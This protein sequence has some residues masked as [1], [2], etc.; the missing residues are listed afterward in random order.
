MQARSIKRTL[1]VALPLGILIGASGA[2][3]ANRFLDEADGHVDRA[4]DALQKA[5][6]PSEQGEYGG[7]RKRAIELLGD[8]KRQIKK[9]REYDERHPT[10][11]APEPKPDAGP[12]P[13]PTGNPGPQPK[14]GPTGGPVKPPVP[15]PTGGATKPNPGASGGAVK[16]PVPNNPAQ[17][18]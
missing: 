14:P 8:V 12:S 18:K 11:P 17:K 15:S 4:I 13:Q 9:A 7:H 6:N 10:K 2:F 16:P 3:A 1:F 5:N